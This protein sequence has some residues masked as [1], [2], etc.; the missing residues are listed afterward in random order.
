MYIVVLTNSNKLWKN[1]GAD[2]APLSYYTLLGI[3]MNGG[4]KPFGGGT[5]LRIC[6]LSRVVRSSI[7]QALLRR[8]KGL[9][10]LPQSREGFGARTSR[11][12][13]AHRGDTW[14]AVYTVEFQRC[15]LC[16]ARMFKRNRPEESLRAIRELDLIRERLKRRDETIREAEL[17]ES[18]RQSRGEVRGVIEAKRK[19]FA[20]LA[21]ARADAESR[22]LRCKSIAFSKRA[23]TQVGWRKFWACGKRRFRFDAQP[24][25]LTFRGTADGN[26]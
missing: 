15:D 1:K 19:V 16:F 2:L 14:R 25:G 26:S 5:S 17:N 9:P 8:S 20:D 11:I 7:G 13:A 24:G 6:G 23:T 21:A 12:V 22:G 18:G 10:T 3:S 4:P